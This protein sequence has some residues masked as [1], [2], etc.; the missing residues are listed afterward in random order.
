MLRPSQ[1]RHRGLTGRGVKQLCQNIT[2]SRSSL[3]VFEHREHE[4]CTGIKCIQSDRIP[5]HI[6][7]F[8]ANSIS[9]APVVHNMH[10]LGAV[11]VLIDKICCKSP[12]TSSLHYPSSRESVAALPFPPLWYHCWWWWW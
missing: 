2:L 7:T 12:T 1:C 5:P 11:A 3:V 10:V 4:S 6:S 8:S 9:N